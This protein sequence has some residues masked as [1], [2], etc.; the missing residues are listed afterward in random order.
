MRKKRG[1]PKLINP[2]AKKIRGIFHDTDNDLTYEKMAVAAEINY[3]TLMNI[4]SRKEV[5]R[6]VMLKLKYSGLIND[7]DEK[8][9]LQWILQHGKRK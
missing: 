7:Q 9:Y 4:F 2:I 5:S 8:D 1:R 3:H 6:F